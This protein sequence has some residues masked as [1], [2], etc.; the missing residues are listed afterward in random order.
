ML[1]FRRG[2]LVASSP[3]PHA[4]HTS[5]LPQHGLVAFS[6]MFCTLP[7]KLFLSILCLH[8]DYECHLENMYFRL[9]IILGIY[10]FLTLEMC[11]LIKGANKV[12]HMLVY[13]K[14]THD[15]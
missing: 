1:C 9:V 5:F 4:S 11:V 15:S 10:N 12:T 14:D 13:M 3:L 2:T 6:V 8:C 7:A